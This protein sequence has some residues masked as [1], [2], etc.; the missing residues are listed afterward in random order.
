[1]LNAQKGVA[2]PLEYLAIGHVSLDVVPDGFHFGGTASF[3]SRIAQA[4]GL[5]TG[6]L[7][8]ASADYDLAT[9]LPG[10]DVVNVIAAHST[11]FT[12]HYTEHGR[13]QTIHAVADTLYGNHVP[14]TWRQT[15]IV[16]LGPIAAEID[17]TLPTVFDG[18]FVGLTPQGLMRRWDAQGNVYPCALRGAEAILPLVDAVILSDEDVPYSAEIDRIRD[19]AQLVVVTHAA[20]GCTVYHDNQSVHIPGQR[21][22]E[23]NPVGAGDVFAASFLIRM[24]MNGFDAVDSA[25][26]ATRIAA[27]SV[28]QQTLSAKMHAIR[29]AI[30][31][32]IE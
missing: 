7:T 28:T 27:I 18:S 26:F 16:H 4:L 20:K 19:L 31:V 24:Q 2:E 1:V 32:N 15:P 21:V 11:T 9:A 22:V 6:V 14:L 5:R 23:V 10:I 13:T 25:E 12:N 3:A 8:S 17:A 30:G 29:A